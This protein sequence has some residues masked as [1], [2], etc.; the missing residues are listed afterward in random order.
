[1]TDRYILASDGRTP[2]RE[3]DLIAWGQWFQNANRTVAKTR[4]K[5]AT[6][7]TVF[8]GLDHSFGKGPPLLFETMVFGG[9]KDQYQKRYSTWEEAEQGHQR[10]VENAQMNFFDRLARTFGGLFG[11]LLVVAVVGGYLAN[12]VKLFS[13]L[14]EPLTVLYVLRMLGLVLF[15]LGIV[16]GYV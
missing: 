13:M 14:N 6:V 5:D 15:P 10:I 11:G 4:L 9:P 1:M 8:L 12:L 7:S 16:L 3:N 2:V